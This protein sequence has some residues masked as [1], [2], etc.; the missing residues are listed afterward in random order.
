[1]IPDDNISDTHFDSVNIQLKN[2]Y[3][4]EKIFKWKKK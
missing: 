2:C 3:E 1:M 4:M